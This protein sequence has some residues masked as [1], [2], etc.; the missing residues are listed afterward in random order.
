M[1][2]TL[3]AMFCI[4]VVALAAC[5]ALAT[6]DIDPL[7]LVNN[8]RVCIERYKTETLIFP[9]YTVQSVVVS[10]PAGLVT[11]VLGS[12]RVV[13]QCREA[14][15]LSSTVWI[16]ISQGGVESTRKYLVKCVVDLDDCKPWI[17][18]QGGSA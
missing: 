11:Y 15:S 17:H 1:W 18:D 3:Q 7:L 4:G 5:D 10:G 8:Q 14:H 12:D 13:L 2:K 6:P 16:R 9:G